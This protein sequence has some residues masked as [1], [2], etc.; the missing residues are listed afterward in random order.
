MG[1]PL[2]T[3]IPER[4]R[5]LQHRMRALGLN[6]LVCLKPQNTFYVSDFNPVIYSHPVVAIL[7][8]DGEPA[9]LVHALRDDHARASSWIR[10]IRLFGAWSTK[11]T[12]GPDWLFALQVILTERG[13]LPGRLGL[14]YDFIPLGV[15]R[16]LESR[17][18]DARFED[19]SELIRHTRFVKDPAEM[20]RMRQAAWLADHG[21]R[22]AIAAEAARHSE[23]E[24]SLAAMAAMN[25]AWVERYPQTEVA[26]FGSLEGGVMNGLWCYCLIGDRI[27]LNCDVPTTRVPAEGELGLIVIW[28]VCDGM[29]AENER[30]VAFGRLDPDR[31]RMY[32]SVLHIRAETAPAIRPGATCADVFCA[33]RAVYERL[34]YGSFLPGRIGHGLGLGPHEPPSLGPADKTPLQP[35]MV[36]TFE[37]NLRI[38]ELGGLQHSDTILITGHGFEF[39]TDLQRDFI[40]V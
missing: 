26:D 27:P 15:M 34:G 3:M 10:D 20:E 22:A 35:G 37:P 33:A 28:T 13:A 11:T 5:R 8:V 21:M 39:L 6:A 38:P 19:A 14:E 4:V 31:Q 30:T 9:L 24:I 2:N 23:R 36:L 18:P 29:H 25:Q 32:E 17:L 7:P 12:M 1:M 40:Q 16:Q